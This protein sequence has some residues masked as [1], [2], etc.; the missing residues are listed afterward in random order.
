MLKGNLKRTLQ[1]SALLIA[2]V[3][4]AGLLLNA[5]L[6]SICGRPALRAYRAPQIAFMPGTGYGAPSYSRFA[7]AGDYLADIAG[8]GLHRWAPNRFPLRVYIGD[9]SRVYGYRPQ[10]RQIMIDSFNEWSRASGGL[11]S[12]RPVSSPSAADIVTGWTSDV[13]ARSGGIEA[14]NTMTWTEVDRRTGN[15]TIRNAKISILT[16]MGR[17]AFSDEEMRKTSLHEVGH[18]LGLE[19][20]SRTRSDIMYAAVNPAQTPYLKDRDV[21]TLKHLYAANYSTPTYGYTAANYP[22]FNQPIPT[23]G[24]TRQQLRD[25][26]WN[27]AK[28]VMLNKLRG[29]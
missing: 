7:Q 11:I 2:L 6:N 14:G 5:T 21:N 3:A 18:S 10:Y 27:M 9:G 23:A 15:G 8:E 29:Y 16:A 25:M 28:Q 1:L 13:T 26:A 4:I 17:H 19:G 24:L 20:H 22:D 12:W